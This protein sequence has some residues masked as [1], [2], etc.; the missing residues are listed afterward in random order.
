MGY[1]AADSAAAMASA[2]A[3]ASMSTSLPVDLSSPQRTASSDAAAAIAAA[4][5]NGNSTSPLAMDAI[6][7][8]FKMTGH[9]MKS[10]GSGLFGNKTLEQYLDNN[11]HSGSPS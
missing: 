11:I 8:Y 7:N 6:Q 1:S 2:S 10:G 9:Q 3:L 4:R 5:A